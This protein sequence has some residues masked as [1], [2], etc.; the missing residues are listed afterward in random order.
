MK[1][2]EDGQVDY[3]KTVVNEFKFAQKYHYIRESSLQ[4]LEPLMSHPRVRF[5]FNSSIIRKNI[6]PIILRLFESNMALFQQHMLALFDQQ[7]QNKGKEASKITGEKYGILRDL[8]KVWDSNSCQDLSTDHSFGPQNT[9]MLESDE[10][11]VHNYHENSL[12]VDKFER[13]DVWPTQQSEKR[14]QFEVLRQTKEDVFEILDWCQGDVQ[15]FLRDQCH[16]QNGDSDCKVK[17]SKYIRKAKK[18]SYE[19][20]M[21]EGVKD[22]QKGIEQIKV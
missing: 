13:S 19:Q 16:D 22:I 11:S 10:I 5:A 8:D 17:L 12:I 18:A 6:M 14:D 15:S 1:K 7:Y 20:K 21:D 2:L 9:L 4:F 3:A